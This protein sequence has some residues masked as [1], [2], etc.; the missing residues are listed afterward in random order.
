MST[1]YNQLSVIDRADK[2]T[3]GRLTCLSIFAPTPSKPPRSVRHKDNYSDCEVAFSV[4]ERNFSRVTAARYFYYLASLQIA[5][6]TD[7]EECIWTN[8]ERFTLSTRLKQLF[9]AFMDRTD[10]FQ[11]WDTPV[12]HAIH[13]LAVLFYSSNATRGMGGEAQSHY[14][15]SMSGAAHG[16]GSSSSGGY[17]GG[18]GNAQPT[19]LSSASQAAVAAATCATAASQPQ[20]AALPPSLGPSS[21]AQA[22]GQLAPVPASF[23][24]PD[25]TAA[26]VAGV[27]RFILELRPTVRVLE[28]H[29]LACPIS[30]PRP[31]QVYPHGLHPDIGVVDPIMDPRF[32]KQG[33]LSDN[34]RMGRETGMP[35]QLGVFKLVWKVEHIPHKQI[36]TVNLAVVAEKKR[37]LHN[38]RCTA[39]WRFLGPS[40][41]GK[42]CT[43]S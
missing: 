23:A 35:L 43:S 42:E 14:R 19:Y 2:Q 29:T 18:G 17:G 30:Q 38:V 25:S 4:G 40:G 20:L 1:T 21:A 10:L 9:I 7:E 22:S 16:G 36:L 28:L 26:R 31:H 3:E 27:A 15:S 39:T 13:F 41:D 37:W 32:R 12:S 24:R 11:S 8:G 6:H 33:K 34:W 5:A